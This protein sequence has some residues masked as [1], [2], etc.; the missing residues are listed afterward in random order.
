MPPA[1]NQSRRQ[2]RSPAAQSPLS[3]QLRAPQEQGLSR[4]AKRRAKNAAGREDAA[5][6]AEAKADP[7]DITSLS[8]YTEP[9]DAPNEFQIAMRQQPTQVVS[10][11]LDGLNALG[12]PNDTAHRTD[13]W[14][15]SIPFGKSPPNDLIDGL[16]IS[17]SPP[18]PGTLGERGGFSNSPSPASPSI[19]KPRPLSYGNGYPN[20][21]PSRYQ[22]GD[23]QHQRSSSN[24][25]MNQIP[26]PH[27]PQPHFHSLPDVDIPHF[28]SPKARPSVGNSYTFCAFDT[29]LTPYSKLN[30]IGGNA[31]LVGHDGCLEVI[32][33]SGDK[34]RL[35]GKLDGLNG[36]VLNA[37]VLTWSSRVDPFASY[38][39]LIAITIHGPAIPSDDGAAS[40]SAD[41]DH[42]EIVPAVSNPHSKREEALQMQTRVQVYSLKTQELITTLYSTKPV[43][44]YDH[45]PGAPVSVS[46]VGNLKIH[47]SGNFVV[48][49]SGTSG[50]VLIYS[51]VPNSSPGAFQCLGK[52]WTSMQWR[53]RRYSETTNSTND[54]DDLQSE[55]GGTST[56]SETPIVSLSGRW[57]AVVPPSH[58]KRNSL[59]GNI[60]S[61]LI[62]RK[63]YGL[64]SHQSPS[65]PSVTCGVDDGEGES[66]LNKFARGVTQ[67]LVKGAR[68]FG[69]HSASTWSSYW[70]KDAQ[71]TQTSAR[72]LSAFDPQP[73]HNLLPPTHAPDTQSVSAGEPDLVSI[74]DLKKLEESSDTKSS[75]PSP[76]ASFQLPYGCSFLS[77]A[78]NGLMLLTTSKKGDVQHIWD[79][80][81]VKHCRTKPFISDDPTSSGV[82]SNPP[83]LHVRQV[84]RFYR[85]TTSSVIDVIW[86]APT[87]EHL[88]IITKK[89]TAHVYDLP[90]T[91]FQWPPLRR[92]AAS[93]KIQKDTSA[94]EEYEEAAPSNPFSAAMKL[95]G[96]KTQPILAAVRGRAPSVG[97]AFSGGAGGFGLSAA[98]GVRGGGKAVAAGLSKSMGAATGTVNTLRHVGE[99][100][101]HLPKFFEDPAPS[102]VAWFG[103][104]EEPILGVIDCGHFKA[105]KVRRSSSAPK[106][107]RQP[108][109][110]S[111]LAEIPLPQNAQKAC[112]LEQALVLN[113]ETRVH[114]F[115]SLSSPTVVRRSS[116]KLKSQPLSQAEIEANAPYQPF[117]TDRRVSLNV[118]PGRHDVEEDQP[119]RWAFGN[120]IPSI[121]LNLRPTTYSDDE[122]VENGAGEN[123]NAGGIENLISLGNAGDNV[124]HVVITAR[125]KKRTK[126]SSG[127]VRG[128]EVDE[129]GFFEDDCDVLD[130]AR[131]RV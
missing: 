83:A 36:R 111:K 37:K 96:G 109:I 80:M 102:R 9:Q 4:Q 46:P 115:W 11:I 29:N 76:I 128:T 54:H 18:N 116:G 74:I 122:D 61:H 30:K 52:T 88:A 33:M 50:E 39:P 10:P 67:E 77:F 16:S 63:S 119:Q 17:E 24:Y 100:R 45:F 129:D 125:R 92:V 108:V 82:P 121:R 98:T 65:R 8:P 15:K 38:R 123:P 93:N 112:G 113:P 47:V 75:F 95:V 110:G 130:F 22:S 89:G 60:P 6:K 117:H 62:Q 12:G 31:L 71:P 127:T 101:L 48:I 2:S 53:E 19:G 131:D 51:I 28:P 21:T 70:N 73:V 66:L 49:A 91:A 94:A 13:S 59:H 5:V 124:E 41:S 1:S 43:P 114:G 23:R 97:A 40:S 35:V 85:L 106:N 81:Q 14:A 42:I 87:G 34:A 26:L 90:H 64:D 20:Y 86:T 58:S 78:P 104:E 107:K 68:W 55:A 126:T 105:Y 79:L 25:N 57:L 118:Y 27:L 99:N 72:R 84:A 56:S 32:G 3:Q 120:N 103:T 7:A 69:G 44:C